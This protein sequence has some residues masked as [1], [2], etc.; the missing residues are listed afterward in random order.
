MDPDVYLALAALVVLIGFA[1]T[2]LPALP[3]VLL[4][5]G[6]SSSASSSASPGKVGLGTW[7]GLVAAAIAKVVIAFAMIATFLAEYMFSG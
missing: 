7:V 5:F 3:E 1:G 6:G 2:V 4:V